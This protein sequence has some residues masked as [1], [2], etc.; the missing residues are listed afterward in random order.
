MANI[1]V[2]RVSADA[3]PARNIIIQHVSVLARV[4]QRDQLR[5]FKV[6][7]RARIIPYSI[8][9]GSQW[10]PLETF[11]QRGGFWR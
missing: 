2:Y 10:V 9:R 3:A 5:I 11:I 4:P 6:S 1:R 8:R 7:V